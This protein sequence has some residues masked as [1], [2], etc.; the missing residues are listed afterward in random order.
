MIDKKVSD[1]VNNIYREILAAWKEKGPPK[2]MC[3]NTPPFTPVLQLFVTLLFA[4]SLEIWTSL[5]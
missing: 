5:V 4:F 3:R 1:K 2:L